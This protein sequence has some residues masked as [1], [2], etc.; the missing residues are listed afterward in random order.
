M[1]LTSYLDTLHDEKIEK[2][3]EKKIIQ[4]I[5]KSYRDYNG[6]NEDDI[7]RL[8]L[9]HRLKVIQSMGE[10]L[11]QSAA[12]NTLKYTIFNEQQIKN[13]FYIFKDVSRISLTEANDPRKLAYETYRINKNEYL[14]LCKYLSPWFIN[15]QPENLANKLFD[16]RRFVFKFRLIVYH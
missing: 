7:N 2:D 9:K 10:T 1:I 5:K 6:I 8:R 14:I 12:K 11:L 15:E 3:E 4:L 13:L 16:V